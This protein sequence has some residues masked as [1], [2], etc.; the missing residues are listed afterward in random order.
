MENKDG[1]RMDEWALPEIDLERCTGCGKCETQCP[2]NAVQIIDRRPEITDR[3]ACSY[4]GICEEI[5]P[6]HAIQLSYQIFP[7]QNS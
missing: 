2:E 6:V 5:C 1:N 4:C 7:P 3:Y